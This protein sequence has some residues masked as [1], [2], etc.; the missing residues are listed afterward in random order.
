MNKRH[1]VGV[2]RL[3]LKALER[4]HLPHRSVLKM[5][6]L[7]MFVVIARYIFRMVQR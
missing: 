6:L 7:K 3:Y 4:F 1:A 2:L 5:G